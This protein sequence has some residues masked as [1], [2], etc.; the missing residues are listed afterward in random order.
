MGGHSEIL[1]K[2]EKIGIDGVTSSSNRMGGGKVIA[3]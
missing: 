1:K 2:S 3:V